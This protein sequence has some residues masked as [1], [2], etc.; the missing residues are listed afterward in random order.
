MQPI[1]EIRIIVSFTSWPAGMGQVEPI[2][3][4]PAE[5]QQLKVKRSVKEFPLKHPMRMSAPSADSTG[6]RNI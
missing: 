2:L 4:V 6:P 5:G 3:A 1:I